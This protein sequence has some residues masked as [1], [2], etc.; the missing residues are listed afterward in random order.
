MM[1][2]L[3]DSAS[4]LARTTRVMTVS[5]AWACAAIHPK[6]MNSLNK[7]QMRI[8]GGNTNTLLNDEK[9]FYSAK[10]QHLISG[11]TFQVQT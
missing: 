5:D 10:I 6:T 7:E 4:A 9:R 8:K 3:A 2:C 11:F 1:L